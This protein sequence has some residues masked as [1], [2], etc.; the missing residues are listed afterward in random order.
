[1]SRRSK[2]LL[3]LGIALACAGYLVIVDLG[4]NA[5]RIHYGVSVEQVDVGGLTVPQAVERLAERGDL[6]KHALVF[7]APGVSCPLLPKAV[8]WGPQPADTAKIALDVGRAHAPFGALVDRVD[9]WV[10]GVH[11]GWAGAVKP[12]KLDVFLDECENRAAGQGFE[13]DREE[14]AARA[15]RAIVTWPRPISFR[16]PLNRPSG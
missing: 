5:G 12:R 13:L 8:G 7:S 1:M 6:L 16:L 14:L 9:A 4:V 3:G 10:G 11:V 2:V 15:E